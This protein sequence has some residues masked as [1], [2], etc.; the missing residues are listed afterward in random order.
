MN[1][2]RFTIILLILIVVAAMYTSG[3]L[4]ALINAIMGREQSQP[5]T[6]GGASNERK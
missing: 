2:P 5:A 6:S 3:R 1:S 4:T